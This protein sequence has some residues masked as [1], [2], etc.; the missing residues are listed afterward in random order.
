MDVK[1]L[2]SNVWELSDRVAEKKPKQ[3]IKN[4]FGYNWEAVNII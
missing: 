2:A 3:N 4:W 1:R